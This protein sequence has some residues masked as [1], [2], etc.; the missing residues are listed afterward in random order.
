M[1]VRD[2]TSLKLP[3]ATLFSYIPGYRPS[4]ACVLL[5][6]P[7]YSMSGVCHPLE[8]FCSAHVSGRYGNGT[9][10]FL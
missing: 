2:Y 5:V 8:F 1:T 10:E 7:R 4:P 6:S 3:D 9:V